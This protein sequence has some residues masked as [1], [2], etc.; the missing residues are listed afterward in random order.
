MILGAGKGQ[1]WVVKCNV[2]SLK[3]ALVLSTVT[4]CES[5]Y[6]EVKGCFQGQISRTLTDEQIHST[7]GIHPNYSTMATV[8]QC[9]TCTELR[10]KGLLKVI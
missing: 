7:A 1:F 6:K 2:S 9:T 4:S 3:H 10:V 5:F 8:V